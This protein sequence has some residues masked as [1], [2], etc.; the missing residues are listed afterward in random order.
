MQNQTK[1][2]KE[3][4]QACTYAELEQLVKD[5]DLLE[6]TGIIGSSLL[7]QKVA[8]VAVGT[9]MINFHLLALGIA[10]AAARELLSLNKLV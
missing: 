6:Q 10:F 2:V 5:Y 3:I 8:E 1:T 4:V 7:R 9:S